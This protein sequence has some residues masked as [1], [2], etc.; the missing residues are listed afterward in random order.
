[1]EYVIEMLGIRKQ[2]GDFVANDNI[3][4]QLQKGEI[5]ALLGENGAG[6]STLMNVLFGLYQP[7]AGE[8]KVNGKEV[9]IT[10]PNKANDLGIGMVHQHFMLVENFTVTENIILGNETTKMGMINIRKA[11]KKV[12]AL[13]EKYGLDVDPY[14]KIE[15][16]S[17]GMQ[18]RVEILKTL[19][20]GAEILIF[21]EPTASLTPLEI[22]ELIQIM[23]RLI[24]EGKS[25][26]LITHKLK[27]IMEVSDRVTIIRKGKGIGTV[28]TSETN[29]D[30]LAEMMVGRQVV[31]KTE[32]TEATPK[33]PVLQIEGLTVKDNRNIERVKNLNLTVR[34]GEIVGIAGIDGNGQSE[35]IEAITGLRKA[36][37]GTI[38]LK[39][40]DITGLK[41]RKIT[42]SGIGHIPQD[43]HKHGLV[44]D[45]PIGH[46]IALQTYYQKP[47]SKGGIIDYK[48]VNKLAKAIVEEYDVRTP[49]IH[50]EARA[51]SGG[52]QQ[53][54]II[55]RE[56]N[57]DPDLLIAALPTRGL[58]VGAIEFIHRRLIEQRNK[59]KAVLLI[60]FELDEVM[61]VSDNIAVI[62]DGSIMDVV[63]PYKTTEQ[64]LGLLMAGQSLHTKQDKVGDE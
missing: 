27:E 17:V 62:Y 40:K 14:A 26:I 56:V 28:T 57:R 3:T 53:K 42:E 54:A 32:K 35:L 30:Q 29:P 31:F 34:A 18:Q 45:F 21:D 60:S 41:P 47:I 64:E 8:I 22:E 58:D 63:K 37:S 11:A 16:I 6:K 20:R 55:G 10:D 13:S 1:M 15:D 59:G 46:N 19:Y 7:E 51:L 12:Q 23:K 33:E 39:G 36:S 5:H 43:R 25:I 4:L 52:N 38:A 49:G 44:L 48:Q 50:T 61:N 24:A 2:F 9:Q